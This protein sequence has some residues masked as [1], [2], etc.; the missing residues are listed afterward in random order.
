MLR[1]VGQNLQSQNLKYGATLAR[2]KVKNRDYWRYPLE[3]AAIRRKRRPRTTA[4]SLSV[5]VS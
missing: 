4:F 1:E 2:T 3:V 5:E